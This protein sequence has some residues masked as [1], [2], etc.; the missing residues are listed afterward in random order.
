[1]E[2]VHEAEKPQIYDHELE[3]QETKFLL[4]VHEI[5]LEL[6]DLFSSDHSFSDPESNHLAEPAEQVK[7]HVDCF[8]LEHSNW[9]S[10]ECEL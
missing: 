2:D 3:H 7:N 6:R 4:I 8:V 1:V 5:T 9:R 10:E